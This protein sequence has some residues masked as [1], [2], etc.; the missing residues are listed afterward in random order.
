MGLNVDLVVTDAEEHVVRGGCAPG[1]VLRRIET[2]EGGRWVLR[3]D[4]YTPPPYPSPPGFPAGWRLVEKVPPAEEPVVHEAG[5]QAVRIA[6]A[7]SANGRRCWVLSHCEK[8]ATDFALHAADGVLVWAESVDDAGLHFSW[9]EGHTNPTTE[10]G[11]EERRHVSARAIEE[12]S[13]GSLRDVE[14]LVRRV[15]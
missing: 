5:H 10:A 14:E 13:G 4:D 11:P 15:A 7:L 12:L 3:G 8:A 6:K 9:E 1:V 2:R